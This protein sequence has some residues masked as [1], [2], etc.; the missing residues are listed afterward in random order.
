MGVRSRV[1]LPDEEKT[2]Q[3]MSRIGGKGARGPFGILVRMQRLTAVKGMP[4]DQSVRTSYAC[5]GV[6]ILFDQQRS[7]MR[8]AFNTENT[9]IRF[10]IKSREKQI[11]CLVC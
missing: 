11:K 5:L 10:G 4:E 1:S 8:E 3:G 6:W 2:G 7:A 9:L